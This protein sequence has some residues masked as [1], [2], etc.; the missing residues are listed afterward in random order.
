MHVNVVMTD[1]LQQVSAVHHIDFCHPG[2]RHSVTH[3]PVGYSFNAESQQSRHRAKPT[4]ECQHS[5]NC[6]Q[7]CWD[8]VCLSPE[9][10]A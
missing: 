7:H 2:V 10:G 9:E 4:P 5:T 3:L 1:P 8:P 6:T